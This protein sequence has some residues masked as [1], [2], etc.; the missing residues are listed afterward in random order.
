MITS[1]SKTSR[2][3]SYK[4]N[5][6]FNGDCGC[7]CWNSKAKHV[8]SDCFCIEVILIFISSIVA[9]KRNLVTLTLQHAKY[10][11]KGASLS[12]NKNRFNK[13]QYLH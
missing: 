9:L 2:D 13:S 7:A 6:E 11:L 5:H 1:I 4:I 10:T 8:E 12:V 3:N